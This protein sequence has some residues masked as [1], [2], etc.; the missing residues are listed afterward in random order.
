MVFP[1]LVY[2]TDICWA[3]FVFPSLKCKPQKL[4][5]IPFGSWSFK[6]HVKVTPRA[7]IFPIT[8]NKKHVKIHPKILGGGFLTHL[9]NM[10]VKLDDFPR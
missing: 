10:L 2:N 1:K 4:F 5:E 9:K 6:N 7:E 8:P 3:F